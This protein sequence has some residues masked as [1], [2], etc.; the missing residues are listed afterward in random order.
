MHSRTLSSRSTPPSHQFFVRSHSSS[1]IRGKVS[2]PT[3]AIK[4]RTPGATQS[5]CGPQ[6][7]SGLACSSAALH[8]STILDSASR[9][10][11]TPRL[12]L[13]YTQALIKRLVSHDPHNHFTPPQTSHSSALTSHNPAYNRAVPI[14]NKLRSPLP[15]RMSHFSIFLRMCAQ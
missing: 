8:L 7:T 9:I 13:L 3:C 6:D 1:H 5:L 10:F 14:Y 2:P 15:A 12:T 11:H 4:H